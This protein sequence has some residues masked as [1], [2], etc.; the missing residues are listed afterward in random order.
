MKRKFSIYIVFI[1]TFL[2]VITVA[3]I[4]A[5]VYREYKISAKKSA[6]Q[7]F[8]KEIMVLAERTAN[9]LH[10]A[11]LTTEVATEVFKEPNLELK[12]DSEEAH[13]LLKALLTHPEIE[14]FYYGDETGSYLQAAD[15][16]DIYVKIIHQQNGKAHTVFN[17]YDKNKKI[18]KTKID[19]DSNYD[20]RKRPWYIGAKK[21]RKAF[22][23]EP[24]I[25]FENAKPGITVAVP[26]FKK[27]KT[28]QG[29]VAADITLHGLSNFLQHIELSDNGLA[30]I[31]D[32]K[33]QLLA[34]SGNKSITVGKG[35][36]IRNLKV[37]ELNIPAVNAMLKAHPNHKENF[38]T[39]NSD[40]KTYY[41]ATIPFPKSTGK[42]WHSTIIAP[43][44]D[45]TGS[46]ERTLANILYLSLGALVIGIL[47][48]T[49]FA[50]RVSK[51]IEL[52]A[53]DVLE[54]RNFNLENN[55]GVNS[56]IHE[57][58][59]MDNAIT[60]MKNSLKAFKLYL[61]A[62]LVKQL[63]ESGESISIGGKEKELTLFF[64][65]IKDYTE[66]TEG[67]PPQ[68]LMTQLSEYFDM[69]TTVIEGKKGTVD[70]FI[71][72]S[73]MAFWNA[74]LSNDNHHFYACQ[75]A[76]ECQ[77]KL[78]ELNAKWKNEG[79]NIFHT[80]IGI[81]TS[82]AT[83]G[84]M[85]AKQRMNYTALGDGVNLASRLEGVNKIYNTTIIISHETYRHVKNLFICRMLDQIAVK[86][87]K[88]PIKIYELLVE[89]NSPNSEEM[90]KFAKQ[91]EDIYEIY[92]KR[93]W[94]KAKDLFEQRLK[95]Y[96]DD[97]VCKLYIKRCEDFINNE[98]PPNW[99]GIIRLETK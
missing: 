41:A 12:L 64:S 22:W 50:R 4:I 49:F 69:M 73:V 71:A 2:I 82:L 37:E 33:N 7:Q 17:F 92:L 21:T 78:K 55:S 85:G 9:Y 88:Q 91:F 89:Y 86:G 76:L 56:H 62:T 40:G 39:F 27:D 5:I 57:I 98:P 80:R 96:P 67:S 38:I 16:S 8:Q 54:V 29:V 60:V 61:P 30:F 34:F 31:T 87:K 36:N 53:A 13:Y 35:K 63:L 72:D 81:H 24:Y 77:R 43:E 90:K 3:G 48:S 25:F 15:F 74:P 65:D 46:M 66:I 19:D 1:F 6:Q 70:K 93:E 75:A 11:Q 79:R 51:P 28:L 23:T 84:N 52:L 97:E 32:S 59:E 14:L 26:I 42:N 45:F 10:I 68:E 47:V 20:P 58:Q 94:T 44:S 18:I 83:V 99:K 95:E